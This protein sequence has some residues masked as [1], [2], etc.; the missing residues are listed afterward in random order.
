MIKGHI[1]REQTVW[2]W[3]SLNATGEDLPTQQLA[4]RIGK[5]AREKF[6]PGCEHHMQEAGPIR[7]KALAEGWIINHRY[8]WMCPNCA[9]AWNTIPAGAFLS[10]VEDSPPSVVE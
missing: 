3:V 1:S 6:Y 7:K 2:C 9:K 5:I 4:A 8:G 10:Y